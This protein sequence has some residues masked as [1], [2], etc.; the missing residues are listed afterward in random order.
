MP[1]WVAIEAGYYYSMALKTDGT[2][3]AWGQNDWGQLG[4]GNLNQ[5]NNPTQIGTDND[6]VS[7]SAGAGHTLALKSNGTLW[8]WGI[9]NHGQL[10]NGINLNQ[11]LN[12]SNWD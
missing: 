8:A 9:N 6:W 5:Q 4:I 11:S 3:W 1:G 10:G 7:V 2:L 12:I